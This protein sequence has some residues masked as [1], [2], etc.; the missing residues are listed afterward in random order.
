VQAQGDG[1]VICPLSENQ[2]QEAQNAWATVAEVFKHDRCSNCHGKKNPFTENT[3]HPDRMTLE[4]DENGEISEARTFDI[5]QGCHSEAGGRW[6]IPPASMH[7]WNQSVEEL[8]RTQHKL[9]TPISF[10]NH[11]RGDKL[12][13]HNFTGLMGL[14][15]DVKDLVETEPYPDPIPVSHAEFVERVESWLEAQDLKG[16]AFGIP[17]QGDEVECGCVPQLYEVVIDAMFNSAGVVPGC[18]GESQIKETVPLDFTSSDGEAKYTGSGTGTLTVSNFSCPV[19]GCTVDYQPNPTDV[20][21]EGDVEKSNGAPSKLT[22]KFTR[23]VGPTSFTITCPCEGPGCPTVVTFQ[24]PGLPAES[25]E[26]G[27]KL[28]ARL[29]EYDR[30][31]PPG[32]LKF[33]IQKRN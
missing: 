24:V 20:Q 5:C 8:C 29:G 10:I 19:S 9:N 11:T 30:S 3:E 26:V 25:G 2:Q 7:W 21:L 14:N 33:T 16:A 18:G 4:L 15:D 27:D 12:I 22:M 13:V 17:W 31:V 23:T 32:T 28:D 1:A 6:H